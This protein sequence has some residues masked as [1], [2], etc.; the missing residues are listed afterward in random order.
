MSEAQ[1][2]PFV[3]SLLE[4]AAQA[5]LPGSGIGWLDAARRENLDAFV[6]GG[7]PDTRM[8]AWKVAPLRDGDAVALVGFTFAGEKGEPIL[9]VEYLLVGAQ[10]YGLRSSPA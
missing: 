3:E 10:T 2:T 4:A 5:Q 7:L 8:E 1:R 9:R 6:A